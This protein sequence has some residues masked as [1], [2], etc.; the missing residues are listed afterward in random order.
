MKTVAVL[1]SF[2]C[3]TPVSAA[4]TAKTEGSFFDRCFSSAR[5]WV[6]GQHSAVPVDR[7]ASPCT[8]WNAANVIERLSTR[9][10]GAD[11]DADG[12]RWV[13]AGAELVTTYDQMPVIYLR[14]D[15]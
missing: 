5:M 4:E 2:A 1:L 7:L 6:L 8:D 12:A 11:V 15:F 9:L 3:L 13:L 14:A 10:T